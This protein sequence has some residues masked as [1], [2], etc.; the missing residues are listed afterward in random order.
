M[1][2]GGAFRSKGA[3]PTTPLWSTVLDAT[4][5]VARHITFAAAVL[6]RCPR[7]GKSSLDHAASVI[8]FSTVCWNQCG[9]HE[10]IRHHSKEIAV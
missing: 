10:I 7:Q 2:E 8:D 1:L 4:G 5:L 9:I 3:G 6:G